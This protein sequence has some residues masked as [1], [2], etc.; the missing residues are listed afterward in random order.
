MAFNCPILAYR[1]PVDPQS[2]LRSYNTIKKQTYPKTPVK[3]ELNPV[4]D[5]LHQIPFTPIEVKREAD[6]TIENVENHYNE[7]SICAKSEPFNHEEWTPEMTTVDES[8]HL[9]DNTNKTIEENTA[10]ET[11]CDFLDCHF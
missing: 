6:N 9:F 2:N 8:V 7:G 1:P 10:I 4:G 11:G 3:L 5:D